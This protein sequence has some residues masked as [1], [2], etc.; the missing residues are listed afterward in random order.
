MVSVYQYLVTETFLHCA[1]ADEK[2]GNAQTV[3]AADPA[4]DLG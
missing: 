1:N 4:D 2:L 3:P